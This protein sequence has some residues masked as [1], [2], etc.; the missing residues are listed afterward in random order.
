MATRLRI[1]VISDIHSNLDAL[2]T[3][4][5]SI[6]EHDQL[7]CLGDIV[8]YGSQPNEVI[9]QIQQLNPS[10]VLMGNHD[11]AIVTGITEGFSSHAA[12][13]I[14]WTRERISLDNLAFLSRLTPSRKVELDSVSIAAY[15]ASPL[16][17]LFDYVFPTLSNP[18][19]TALVRAAEAQVVLLG[20][21]HVPMQYSAGEVML[22]NPGSVGQPRDG[23]PRASYAI[24]DLEGRTLSFDVK[25]VNYDIDSAATKILREG[26]PKFLAD[27]LYMGM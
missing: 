16:D 3:V 5:S 15:H 11:H 8:G 23:D 1:A 20:H 12:E 26:L 19:V 14:R 7:F 25:R 27:R 4:I 13:A 9:A 2:S 10:L 18:E 21:T 22:A 17:P 24:L 6:P